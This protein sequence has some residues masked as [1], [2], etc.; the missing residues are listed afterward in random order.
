MTSLNKL[1]RKHNLFANSD[2]YKTNCMGI[3]NNCATLTKFSKEIKNNTLTNVLALGFIL[4]FR[5]NFELQMIF[6]SCMC[7]S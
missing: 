3:F 6:F 7:I 5:I 4:S 1:H 2:E